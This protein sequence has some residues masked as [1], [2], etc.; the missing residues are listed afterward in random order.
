[1][2]ASNLMWYAI[3]VTYGRELLFKEFL[4]SQQIENFIPMHYKAE[5]KGLRKKLKLVPVIHNLVFV[6]AEKYT[7]DI[8]K[9]DIE[10]RIPIRYLIDRGTHLP[11]I[12]PEKQ[13]INF[14]KVAGQYEEQ[15]IY[16]D[17]HEITLKKG[18]KVRITGGIFSGVEGKFMRVKGDRR[19]V[20]VIQGLM[21]I[22]TTFVHP[23]LVEPC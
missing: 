7:I 21:A 9:H 16:L 3:R 18:D 22:A 8:I 14:I 10:A 6:H 12:V 20:V 5:E 11:I 2:Q 4:D 17:P 13:M 19:V 23:S 1:M 15:L